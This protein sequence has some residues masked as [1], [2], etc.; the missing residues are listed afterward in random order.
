[1]KMWP[2]HRHRISAIVRRDFIIELSYQLRL[3]IRLFTLVASMAF[4][5]YVSEFVG[6]PEAL[7]GYRGGYFDYVIIG[8]G[9]TGYM[10]LGMGAFINRINQEQ[11]TGTFEIL[12]AG[13]TPLSVLL[14]A[15]FIVPFAITT[16]ELAA[17]LGFGLGVIGGGISLGA[18]LIALPL[19][20]LTVLSFCAFG[21]AGAALV[22]LAKRGDVLT[23]PLYQATLVFSGVLFPVSLF[24]GFV[25]PVAYLFPSFYGLRGMRDA[26]LLDAGFGDVVDDLVIVAAFCVV[27]LPASIWLFARSITVAKRLGVLGA[28]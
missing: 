19:A 14:L 8:I 20:A 24:P 17:L 21:I 18:A 3:V 16:V 22:V 9:L 15:G 11:N 13:P 12:L 25:R 6:Q 5:Y 4:M 28:Y 2:Q 10:S 7:A 27:L 26:L 1:M 23:G